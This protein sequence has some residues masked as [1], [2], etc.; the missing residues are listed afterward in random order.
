MPRRDGNWIT[1]SVGQTVYEDDFV[2]YD[3]KVR[4]VGYIGLALDNHVILEP[5]AGEDESPRVSA[6]DITKTAHSG[7]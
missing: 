6:D 2:A 5:L 1:D 4:Q 3:G 7:R